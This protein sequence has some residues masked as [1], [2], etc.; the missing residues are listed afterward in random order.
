MELFFRIVRADGFRGPDMGVGFVYDRG[1]DSAL[2]RLLAAVRPP[3]NPL[4]G[5]RPATIRATR[6][7]LIRSPVNRRKSR[8]PDADEGSGRDTE[9]APRPRALQLIHMCACAQARAGAWRRVWSRATAGETDRC[10]S[11]GTIVRRASRLRP[12]PCRG[13]SIRRL[14]C[15]RPAG[16]GPATHR[17]FCQTRRSCERNR[18]HSVPTSRTTK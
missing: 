1:V 11:P 9:A 2:R 17:R 8:Q 3:P 13:W 15:I 16:C 4:T 12:S 14:P 10:R 7:T 18:P 6:V 5:T